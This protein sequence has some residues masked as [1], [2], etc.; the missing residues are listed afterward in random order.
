MSVLVVVCSNDSFDDVI[1]GLMSFNLRSLLDE[2]ANVELL[3][4]CVIFLFIWLLLLSKL[5]ILCHFQ[6]KIPSIYTIPVNY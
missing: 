3:F 2:V 1:I 5:V 6:D 4:G